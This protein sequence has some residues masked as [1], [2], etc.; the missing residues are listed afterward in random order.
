MYNYDVSFNYLVKN[1]GK[2]TLARFEC[3]YMYVYY[4]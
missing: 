2:H 3:V 4:N 1:N